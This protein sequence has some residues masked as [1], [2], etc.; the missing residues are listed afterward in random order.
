MEGGVQM[1]EKLIEE[2][3]KTACDKGWYEDK[4]VSFGDTITNIHGEV[5][6]VW[7]EFRNH[8]AMNE[9]Y[10]DEKGKPCG[11]PTE[12]AD[13]I[14]RVFSACQYYGIDIEEA[15]KTK[16]EFNK[17]REWKHGGKKV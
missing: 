2:I 10:L 4:R 5:S 7:E 16:M 12:M 13:I 3:Y 1:L 11:I 8:R 15:I 6:E 14:I 9:V 17:T